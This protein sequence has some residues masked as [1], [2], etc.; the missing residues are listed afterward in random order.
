MLV[1]RAVR[2]FGWTLIGS[3][4]LLLL[5]VAYLLWFTGLSTSGAQNELAETW[6]QMVLDERNP[7]FV[8]VDIDLDTGHARPTEVQE[9]AQEPDQRETGAD[10]R[11]EV[12]DLAFAALWFE[13]D[14]ERI[15][16]DDPLFV[17][18]DVDLETLKSGPG[19]YPDSVGPG[20]DGNFAVAGH[21][22]TYGAPFRNISELQVG[23]T[24]HVMDRDGIEHVYT[25]AD[26]RVVQP[27]EMWV[28]QHP[29]PL[30]KD[31]PT[32]TLT[33]C[34]PLFSAAQRLVVWATYER[35]VT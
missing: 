7:T 28:V 14:G 1:L 31:K 11:E 16:Q 34:H 15:V 3:S 32:L 30:Q 24:I 5:Y 17:L 6:S 27:N 35:Q 2:Y 9:P 12:P 10:G 13:R 21:R 29:D 33:T 18:H 20:Q 19:H 22:T 4:V 26:S 25:F 23:D 8:P